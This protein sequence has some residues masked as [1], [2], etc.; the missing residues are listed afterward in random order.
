MILL[1]QNELQFVDFRKEMTVGAG[2]KILFYFFR[3]EP[4][5]KLKMFSD[6]MLRP[7]SLI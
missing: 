2:A 7:V 3:F 4:R 1:K 6:R 5:E